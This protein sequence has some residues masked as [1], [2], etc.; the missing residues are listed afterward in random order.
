LVVIICNSVMNRK[1]AIVVL[2]VQ[3]GL[4]VLHDICFAFHANYVFNRLTLVVLL[5]SSSEKVV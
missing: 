5:S 1:I 2:S 4:N 3:F